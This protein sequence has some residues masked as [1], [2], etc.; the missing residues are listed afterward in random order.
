MSKKHELVTASAASAG[1]ALDRLD[2][3]GAVQLAARRIVD[4]QTRSEELHGSFVGVR[5]VAGRITDVI[6][7]NGTV[8]IEE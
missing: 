1:Q 7:D 5:V 8:K 6:A 2:T 3:F 4:K